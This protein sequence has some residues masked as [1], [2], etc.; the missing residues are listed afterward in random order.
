MG[1]AA[2]IKGG[3]QNMT[4]KHKNKKRSGALPFKDYATSPCTAYPE[5][6]TV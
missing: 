6:H 1:N 5:R 4:Q 2:Y 3:R